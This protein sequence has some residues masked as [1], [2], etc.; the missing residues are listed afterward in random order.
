MA[1]WADPA[2]HQLL[3]AAAKLSDGSLVLGTPLFA[4]ISLQT[5]YTNLNIPLGQIWTIKVDSA[6]ENDSVT[7]VLTNG[8]K[9]SGLLLTKQIAMETLLGRVGI[10]SHVLDVVSIH[11]DRGPLPDRLDEGLALYYSF[12]LNRNDRAIDASGKD[13]DGDVRGATWTPDGRIGGAF[14]FD[15]TDD[16]VRVTGWKGI[17]RA[18]PRTISLWMKEQSPGD[19]SP[20]LISLTGGGEGGKFD[21]CHLFVLSRS[22]SA[23]LSIPLY[24]AEGKANIRDKAWHHVVGTHDGKALRLYVDGELQEQ[25][26]I[27]DAPRPSA[28]NPNDVTIGGQDA[29]G[30]MFRGL[31]DEVR[32]YDRALSDDEVKKLYGVRD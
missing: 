23:Y 17:G 10:A 4:S 29:G 3:R 19:G 1:V 28:P 12:D 13:R 6:R 30:R 16:I 31:L 24:T 26:R 18:D 5:S 25:Q 15:G 22:S 20:M 27:D 32:I 7:V 14:S 2:P 21:H 8:D 11:P 9:L